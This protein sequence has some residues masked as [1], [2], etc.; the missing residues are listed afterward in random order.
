MGLYIC[1]LCL[2]E[3]RSSTIPELCSQCGQRSNEWEKKKAPLLKL[4]SNNKEIVI[5]TEK[6]TI[7]RDNL[8]IFGSDNYKYVS[9]EQF[10]VNYGDK[11]WEIKGIK[12]VVNITKLNDIDI[13]DK[14]LNISDS[15][16]IT[17]GLLDLTVSLKEK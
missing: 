11:G 3:E 1:K 5:Y 16:I 13:A 12:G 2:Q 14:T 6:K 8:R 4:Q 15:D 17:I 9:N 10:M 7:G